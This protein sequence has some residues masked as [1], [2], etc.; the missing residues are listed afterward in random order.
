MFKLSASLAEFE[1]G[2]IRE[3]TTAV[4]TAARAQGRQRR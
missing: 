2:I 3:R 1:Y 4:L